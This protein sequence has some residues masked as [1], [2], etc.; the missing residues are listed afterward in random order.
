MATLSESMTLPWA[1]G[2]VV[3]TATEARRRHSMLGSD[4]KLLA[5]MSNASV[6]RGRLLPSLVELHRPFLTGEW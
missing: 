2:A 3:E 6:L 5:V 1:A 4:A